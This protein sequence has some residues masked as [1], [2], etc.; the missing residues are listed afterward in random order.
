MGIETT[1]DDEVMIAFEL[2][3]WADTNPG[4]SLDQLLLTRI[5]GSDK[6]KAEM[7]AL[8]LEYSDIFDTKIRPQAATVPPMSIKIDLAKWHVNSN[9]G[10]P[11]LHSAEKQAEIHKQVKALLEIGAIRVSQALYH[12]Q[13][14]LTPKPH[15]GWRFCIDYRNLN[16]AS[17]G[18]GWPIPVIKPMLE[19]L[20]AKRPKVFA[21]MDMPSGYHQAPLSAESY[22]ATAFVT[23]EGKYEFTR[24]PMGLVGATGFFQQM[25]TMVLGSLVHDICEVYLDDILVHAQSEAELIANLRQIFE[26]IRRACIVINPEKCTFGIN[27]VEFVGHTIND[28]HR[29]FT[30][31]KLEGVRNVALPQTEKQLRAFVGLANYFRDHI[32]NFSTHTKPLTNLLKT[33]GPKKQVVWTEEALAA[34][35]RVKTLIDECPPLYHQMENAPLTL[36]TDASDY[37]IG[38]YL[39]QTVA[40]KEKPLGFLSKSLSDV[41]KRWATPEKEGYAIYYALMYWQHILLGPHF[42]IKTD[43][44]NLTYV[45][46]HGSAKVMR[47]K[48]AILDF[49]FEIHHIAGKDNVVADTLSRLLPRE[50]NVVTLLLMEEQSIPE[51]NYKMIQAVHNAEVGHHGL[52]RTIDLLKEKGQN[53]PGRRTQARK[54]IKECPCCQKFERKRL[55]HATHP[56]TTSSYRPMERINADSIG[57]ISMGGE[58]QHILVVVDCFTRFV[59]LTPVKEVTGIE[60]ADAL[61]QHANRYGIPTVL[62]TDGGTQFDNRWVHDLT[63][64]LGTEQVTTTAYSKEENATVERANKEVVRHLQ[65]I[66]FDQGTLADWPKRLIEV[67]RIINSTVHEPVGASP[68]ALMFGG[69]VDLHKGFITELPSGTA[70]DLPMSAWMAFRQ[71]QHRELLQ[72]AERFQRKKDEEHVSA[73]LQESRPIVQFDIGSLVLVTPEHGGKFKGG[74]STKLSPINK[75]PLRVIGINKDTY[76]LESLIGGN[77]EEVH[78]SRIRPL[79]IDRTRVDP[80]RIAE[81]DKGLFRI[82]KI[83]RHRGGSLKSPKLKKR[84]LEFLVKWE[85]YPDSDNQWRPWDAVSSTAQLHAYLRD[86]GAERLIP[87]RLQ[88][89]DAEEDDNT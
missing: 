65:N 38:A 86:K 80:V 17:T 12:S 14:H 52:E 18:M 7:M 66:L 1:T 82:E 58:Y 27:E 3:S 25:M 19:R 75:G 54:F 43:H 33:V 73:R 56:F 88:R 79:T 35:E 46:V 10:A 84:S 76:T 68:A 6:F 48:L 87:A 28:E 39:Y 26:R 20:G 31:T 36:L 83:L 50:E 72:R 8:C 71:E 5:Y 47:W 51:A 11:R 61:W 24:V 74:S 57:P 23:S 30:R 67:Q 9:R 44:K 4:S 29:H 49:D 70:P 85:G 40:G 62:L 2:D 22:S 55:N 15:G 32:L 78:V 59:E 77:N 89:P 63:N 41:Q 45:S 21:K 34:F 53:W 64:S 13:V 37:G 60:A 16:S 81:V 42:T 69:T